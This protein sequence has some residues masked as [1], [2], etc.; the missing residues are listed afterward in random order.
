MRTSIRTVASFISAHV[1]GD[2]FGERDC[3]VLL[4]RCEHGR[5]GGDRF[6]RLEVHDQTSV[7]VDE[8][9]KRTASP[10]PSERLGGSQDGIR[11]LQT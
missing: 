7:L 11:P 2:L 8:M 1:A 3:R 10:M 6:L 5:Q 4:L 9:P